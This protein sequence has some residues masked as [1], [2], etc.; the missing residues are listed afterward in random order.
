MYFEAIGDKKYAPLLAS[1]L[2]LPGISGNYFSWECKR[3]TFNLRLLSLRQVRKNVP[4]A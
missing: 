3:F 1:K 2:S 4:T